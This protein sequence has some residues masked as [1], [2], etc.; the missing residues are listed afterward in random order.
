MFRKTAIGFVGIIIVVIA[1]LGCAQ[2]APTPTPTTTPPLTPTTTPATPTTT[3]PLTPAP[4]TPTPTATP[5]P[6]KL[7]GPI[8]ICGL[9]DPRVPVFKADVEA[10][11]V[12][13][14]EINAAGGILGA[15]VEF[16]H[17][18]TQRRVD[19]AVAAYRSAVVEKKCKIVLLEGVSEEAYAIIEEG[20]RL[21]PSYPHIVISSQAGFATTMKVMQNYDKYKFYFRNLPPDPDLNYNVPKTY[22]EI[23]KA[24]GVKRVALLLEDAAWTEC[25]RKGCEFTTPYGTIGS[26]AMKDWVQEEY[27]L[28]VVYVATIAVGQKD[29]LPMLEESARR[30]AQYIFVLSSWYTDTVTL[31]KQWAES[32]AKN[33]PL[34]LFGGPNQ[35]GVFYKLTGGKAL[36]VLTMLYDT[37]D[38]PPVSSKTKEVVKKLNAL[39]LGVDMSVHYYYSEVYRVKEA[40]EKAGSLDM[41]K[42]IKAMEELEFEHT[43]VPTKYAFFGYKNPNFHSYTGGYVL[44]AQFQCNGKPAWIT[45]PELLVDFNEEVQK[46]SSIKLYKSPEELRKICPS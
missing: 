10:I 14:D 21:Y 32:G 30:G 41:D 25:A 13:V 24:I 39:G 22:F 11:K 3:P 23:A 12:A 46:A 38:V 45:P 4:T 5:T 15:K 8:V 16:F 27:G 42:V 2:P 44:V 40:I 20:A 26:K 29:F 19:L 17:E 6:V 18:D 35:W 36:G 7:E 9:F 34:A 37:A 31:T 43:S 33:I 1:L 28:E